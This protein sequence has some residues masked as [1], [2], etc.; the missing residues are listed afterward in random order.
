MKNIG[1]LWV[2]TSKKGQKYMSGNLIWED[3]KIH[4]LVFKNDRRDGENPNAPTYRIMLNEEKMGEALN[5]P[6]EGK[7]PV[8]Y[9]SLE[10]EDDL[11][12]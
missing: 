5:R 7:E 12:F 6:P 1:G 3:L 2:N 8:S 11:P 9:D 4:L 10:S